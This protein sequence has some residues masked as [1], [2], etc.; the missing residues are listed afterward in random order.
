M[1]W[2]KMNGNLGIRRF[3]SG[4]GRKC[5]EDSTPKKLKCELTGINNNTIKKIV[6]NKEKETHQPFNGVIL[7]V[8]EK[9]EIINSIQFF[10]DKNKH[11]SNVSN[12]TLFDKRRGNQKKQGKIYTLLCPANSAFYRIEALV[13]EDRNI[14]YKK[15]VTD[16]NKNILV[17]YGLLKGIAFQ[18]RDI[19][20]GDLKPLRTTQGD[21]KTRVYYGRNPVPSDKQYRYITSEC[22]FVSSNDDERKLKLPGFF[23]GVTVLSSPSAVHGLRMDQCS[24]YKFNNAPY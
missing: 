21:Y 13:S 6:K 17:N 12:Y 23:S 22:G 9:E 3:M 14:L 5:K 15:N 8:N 7:D 4:N 2:E 18:C 19:T 10:Y 11:P 20:T 1:W 16:K 24:Y